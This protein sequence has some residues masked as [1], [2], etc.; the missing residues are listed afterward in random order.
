M[1]S[2]IGIKTPHQWWKL[3][4][5]INESEESSIIATVRAGNSGLGNRDTGMEDFGT[6]DSNNRI[7]ICPLCA[8]LDQAD[9]RGPLIK[10]LNEFHVIMICPSLKEI[11]EQSWLR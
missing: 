3:Q 4:P 1:R 8:P 7:V 10:K 6:T 2:F 11:R 5:Y 9:Y